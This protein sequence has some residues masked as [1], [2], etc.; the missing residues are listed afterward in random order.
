MSD[1]NMFGNV[2]DER[3]ELLDQIGTRGRSTVWLAFDKRFNINVAVKIIPNTS[4][5]NIL[6]ANKEINILKK[7]HHSGLPRFHDYIK[8]SE[9]IFIITTFVEGDSFE[10]ILIQQGIQSEKR[11][12]N[13][14]IQLCDILTYLYHQQ[15]QIIY[16]GLKMDNVV[17][18]PDGVVVLTSLDNAIISENDKMFTLGTREY[19]TSEKNTE[20]KIDERSVVYSLGL[21]MYQLA[22]GRK[23][24]DTQ[25]NL[26][27]LKK[28]KEALCLKSVIKKCIHPNP[29]KRY[30]TIPDI[31]IKLDAC[32]KKRE[33]IFFKLIWITI[34]KNFFTGFNKMSDSKVCEIDEIISMEAVQYNA[35]LLATLQNEEKSFK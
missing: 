21:I 10:K 23:P 13:W 26:Y 9:K 32:R 12:I 33:L 27:Y 20:K 17:L 24:D 11:I 28:C 22:T 31:L 5:M 7:I 18:K 4:K 6:F 1:N 19:I 29:E 34:K 35:D 16:A 8:T 15:P 2:L 25:K 30:Q 3:Y 14:G